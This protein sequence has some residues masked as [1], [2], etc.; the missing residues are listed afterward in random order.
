MQMTKRTTQL[1][2]SIKQQERRFTVSAEKNEKFQV[3]TKKET[4]G[5]T[6]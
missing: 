1:T 5:E 6:S 4:H 2:S 3:F